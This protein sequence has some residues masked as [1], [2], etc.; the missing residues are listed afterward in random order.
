ML[1]SECSKDHLP[2]EH[3]SGSLK[4]ICHCEPCERKAW[5]S[6]K[7]FRQGSLNKQF[8]LHQGDCHS[9]LRKLRNDRLNKSSLNKIPV[10]ASLA[11]ARRG[12]LLNISGKAIFQAKPVVNVVNG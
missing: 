5:Q 6:P 2:L 7:S 9:L 12:N 11:N 8:L 1:I 4:Y 3:H 10:I